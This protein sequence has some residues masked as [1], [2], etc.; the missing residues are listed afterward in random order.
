MKAQKKIE[1][2]VKKLASSIEGIRSL[3]VCTK[4]G[5]MISTIGD[6]ED[7]QSLCALGAKLISTSKWVGK[8]LSLEGFE[9]TIV[10]FGGSTI[11]AYG[12]GSI[13]I[14]ALLEKGSNIELMKRLV[15]SSADEIESII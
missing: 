9:T 13:S 7:P 5:L 10:D 11:L 14:I 12:H 8:E 4:E 6:R 2:A 1:E 3:V 15:R